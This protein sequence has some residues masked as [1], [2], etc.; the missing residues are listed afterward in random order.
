M[1]QDSAKS[2]VALRPKS[3]AFC[4]GRTYVAAEE[5]VQKSKTISRQGA[6]PRSFTASSLRSLRLGDFARTCFNKA[7]QRP[8]VL[9]R[10]PRIQATEFPKEGPMLLDCD[11]KLARQSNTERA[12]SMTHCAAKSRPNLYEN[13]PYFRRDI[14]ALKNFGFTNPRT[15]EVI[16]TKDIERPFGSHGTWEGTENKAVAGNVRNRNFDG[17]KLP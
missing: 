4:G 6:K 13:R 2:G 15:W 5:G 7:G 1:N 9:S 17:D 11:E 3:D 10:D 14:V 16:E 12:K 8:R